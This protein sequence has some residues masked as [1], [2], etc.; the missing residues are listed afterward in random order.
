MNEQI[1]EG[2]HFLVIELITGEVMLTDGSD[3]FQGPGGPGFVQFV[4]VDLR[5]ILKRFEKLAPPR[6]AFTLS[7]VAAMATE[8]SPTVNSWVKSGLLTPS[9][10][11]R[12]GTRGRAMLFSRVDAF[13]A[14]L[15]ASL[16]RRCG[17]PLSTLKDVS[18][19][20]SGESPTGKSRQ[21]TQRAKKKSPRA[22]AKKRR[23]TKK[24][25]TRQVIGSRGR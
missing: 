13:V 23:S 9:I 18:G 22:R 2:R 1:S 11:D 4:T 24:G 15:L 17:L 6:E 8:K 7:E 12:N 21:P 19:V 10:R 14:C 16:R 5:E 25:A 3:V 20:V